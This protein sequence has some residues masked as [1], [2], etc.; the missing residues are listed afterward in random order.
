MQRLDEPLL[1]KDVETRIRPVLADFDL[2]G[3]TPFLQITAPSKP[4]DKGAAPFVFPGEDLFRL[5]STARRHLH[6]RR[7]GDALHRAD[8]RG[9][10]RSGYG[11][12]P[13][14][15]PGALTLVDPGSSPQR[16]L[17]QH[18]DARDCRAQVRP[19]D[20]PRPWSNEKRAAIPRASIGVIGGLFFQHEEHLARACRRK[21]PCSFCRPDRGRVC[22]R[23]SPFL[24]KSELSK[25]AAGAEDLWQHP[26]APLAMKLPGHRLDSAQRRQASLDRPRANYSALLLESEGQEGSIRVRAR[27]WSFSSGRRCRQGPTAR[28]RLLVLDLRIATR[29]T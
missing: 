26:C 21:A 13:A 12:G 27:R 10:R 29:R 14:G 15:Q 5:G 4:P 6:P 18:A 22:V 3:P 25:K 2:F 9:R 24:P 17:G 19:A 28:P 20:G 16:R 8:L 11:A 1:R 7:A 23:R